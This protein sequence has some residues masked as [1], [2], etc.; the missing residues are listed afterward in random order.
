MA[1]PF[2]VPR[3][4]LISKRETDRPGL[5]RTPRDYRGPGSVRTLP[6]RKQARQRSR[7]EN[8]PTRAAA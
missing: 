5:A 8:G 6:S 3:L 1:M 2:A 4:F 7:P